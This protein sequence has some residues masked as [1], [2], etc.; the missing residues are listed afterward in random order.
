MLSLNEMFTGY[1]GGFG[2]QSSRSSRNLIEI[3]GITE[4]NDEPDS[5][6]R[7]KIQVYVCNF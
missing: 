3:V 6:V 1:E 5:E 4:Q 7:I 2:F